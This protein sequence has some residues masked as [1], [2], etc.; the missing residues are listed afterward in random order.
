MSR[1]HNFLAILPLFAVLSMSPIELTSHSSGRSIASV[2]EVI[3]K[4]PLYEARAAKIDRTIIE[5][6]KDIDKAKLEVSIKSI[7]DKLAIEKEIKVD[8]E[9]KES[10]KA[11]KERIEVLV[12]DIVGL[13]EDRKA[14][15]KVLAEKPEA[16]RVIPALDEVITSVEA[17][18]SDEKH[19]DELIAKLEPKKEEPAV[20]KPEEPK[21]E[22]AE[23][24]VK[25]E[26]PKKE[27]TAKE[28]EIACLK[29]E[30]KVLTQQ[31]SDLSE[32]QKKITENLTALTNMMG[33]MNQRLYQSQF[34]QWMMSGPMV[35]TQQ[36][37]QPHLQGGAWLYMPQQPMI[38]QQGVPQGGYIPF[39]QQP[40]QLGQYNYQQATQSNQYDLR[41]TQPAPLIPQDFGVTQSS[42]FSYGFGSTPFNV[43]PVPQNA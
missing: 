35:N 7:Q 24:A 9:D 36:L 26:E 1:S 22:E 14:V 43:A 31:L 16:E 5:V 38:V 20:V 17:L 27:E 6:A 30:N 3:S 12:S 40:S 39:S 29:E 13:E 25:P 2:E 19:N 18:L 41:Y 11:S 28:D 15:E 10:V 8:I 21:K 37:Y 42:P 23:V 34:P 33:Q 32:Q 4:T